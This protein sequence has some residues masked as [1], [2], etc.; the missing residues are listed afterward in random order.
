MPVWRRVV[1]LGALG[2]SVA[3]LKTLPV[4][5]KGSRLHLCKLVPRYF[6]G[7]FFLRKKK[8]GRENSS[9]DFTVVCQFSVHPIQRVMSI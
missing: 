7:F 5:Q 2:P 9:K 6:S 4:K 8:V 1:P 3:Q